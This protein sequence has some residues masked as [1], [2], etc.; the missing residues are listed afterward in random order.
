MY[1]ETAGSDLRGMG[2]T[3][4]SQGPEN[5][6]PLCALVHRP[7]L[8]ELQEEK[9]EHDQ[10]TEAAQKA[11][12]QAHNDLACQEQELQEVQDKVVEAAMQ[13]KISAD[14]EEAAKPAAPKP[15]KS[16]MHWFK[17]KNQTAG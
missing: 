16:I 7:K 4:S 17:V 9:T 5:K 14:K 10:Q 6:Y 12:Y 13:G 8:E 3:S 1:Y 11:W 15:Q 2:G